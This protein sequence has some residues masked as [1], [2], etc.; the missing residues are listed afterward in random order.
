MQGSRHRGDARL[1][2]QGLARDGVG[3]LEVAGRDQ[4][5]GEGVWLDLNNDGSAIDGSAAAN[6]RLKTISTASWTLIEVMHTVNDAQWLG[7][8]DDL[9]TVAQVEEVRS[10]MFWGDFA[11]TSFDAD[12][13]D[14]GTLWFDNLL[15]EVFKDQAA[16]T[17]NTNPNPMLS[18]G[19]GPLGDFNDDGV[20]DGFFSTV[21]G[22]A[23]ACVA[24]PP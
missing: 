23:F 11:G 5:L 3:V 1:G 4:H 20:V 9:Y 18:E 17:P 13:P 6:G 19:A 21:F 22:F 16:V 8:G 14:G 12:G 10:V 15:V 7:I 2:R 24:T